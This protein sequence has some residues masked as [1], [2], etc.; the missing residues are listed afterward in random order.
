[1]N[2][3]QDKADMAL[4]YAKLIGTHEASVSFADGE[5]FSVT[6]RNGAVETVQDYK[7]QNYGITVYLN[8]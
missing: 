4:K 7:D 5:G 3:H 2:H 8:K 1:M 6:A